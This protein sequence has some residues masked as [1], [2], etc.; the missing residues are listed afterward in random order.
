MLYLKAVLSGFVA[1]SIAYILIV[2]VKV[3]RADGMV[4]VFALLRSP[5]VIVLLTIA[6][7]AGLWLTLHFAG[8]KTPSLA[9]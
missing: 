2:G 6:F 3:W 7:G 1:A 9:P 4:P 5:W 8:A